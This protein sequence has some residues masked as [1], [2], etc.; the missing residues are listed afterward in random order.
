MR[1]HLLTYKYH[2]KCHCVGANAYY[3][4]CCHF[5]AVWCYSSTHLYY[6][7]LH[8]TNPEMHSPRNIVESVFREF[9]YIL[10]LFPPQNDGNFR[11]DPYL[12]LQFFSAKCVQISIMSDNR[13]FFYLLMFKWV[14]QMCCFA[15]AWHQNCCFWWWARHIS[16]SRSRCGTYF[17]LVFFFNNIFVIWCLIHG[18][19]KTHW[20]IWRGPAIERTKSVCV[21]HKNR[22]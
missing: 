18:Q 14:G 15:N 10:L 17:L 2:V 7:P 11:I 5:S 16:I 19:M 8:F 21:Y 12:L 22:F 20:E 3:F 4:C 13:L 6:F 9:P 1:R